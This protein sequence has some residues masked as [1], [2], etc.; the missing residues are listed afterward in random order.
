[1][2]FEIDIT[3]YEL[4]ENPNYIL[5]V[6]INSVNFTELQNEI[7]E[8]NKEIQWDGMW[9]LDDAK[10]RLNSNWKLIIYRP[11]KI[12]GWYWLDNTNEPRN[13]Y[14]NHN[15]R[16]MGI[17]KEMHFA[18]LNVCKRLGMNKVECSIDDWNTISIKCIK[19]AGWKE[20]N[21]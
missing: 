6:D 3:E 4:L 8:F 7:D 11:D 9:N 21:K 1:M 17:G 5:E 12:R 16:N 10:N 15:F 19:K 14:I 2:R 13:L 18:L 20:S